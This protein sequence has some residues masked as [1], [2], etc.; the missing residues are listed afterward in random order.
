MLAK[1]NDPLGLIAKLTLTA[2]QIYRQLC[3]TK[4]QWNTLYILLL[5]F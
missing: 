1:I 5:F 3:E 2:K 4:V